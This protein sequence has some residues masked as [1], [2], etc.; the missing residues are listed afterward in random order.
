MTERKPPDKS[1]ESWVE[2]Q[3]REAQASGSFDNLAG[4]GQPIPGIS[5]PYG[6]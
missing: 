6:A 2:E 3:I 5:G 4:K 1:W